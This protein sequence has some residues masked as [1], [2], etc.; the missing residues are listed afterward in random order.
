[1][2]SRDEFFAFAADV[3]GVAP[4]SLSFETTLGTIPEWDSMAQLRL[5]VEMESRWGAS[6]PFAD[7]PK[8][9]SLWE[10][11]RRLNSLSPKKAVAVDLDGTL[12]NGVVGEDGAAAL[13]PNAALLAELKALKERGVLLTILS[14]NNLGDV[15]PAFE[16]GL[17][18]PLSADDFLFPQID[19]EPKA[20]NLARLAK[21]L[22]LGTDAFVFV[23]DSPV[24][25]LEMASRL[26]D[27]AVASFPPVLSAYFPEVEVTDED[28]RKTEEYREEAERRKFLSEA[29]PADVWDALGCWLDVHRMRPDEA[30]RVAQLSQRANQ[31]STCTNRYAADD[32]VALAADAATRVYVVRAGDDFGEM[33]LVAFV[34][35]RGGEVADFTMSCRAAGRGLEE[36]TWAEVVR[37]LRA[38][39]VRELRAT[40]RDSGRNAPVRDLFERLGF[41]LAAE[42]PGK[43]SSREYRRSL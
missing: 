27:V 1:M 38:G 35:V 21:R 14:K 18:A 28:R 17:L 5:V 24:E 29:R 10:L 2:V 31:F 26:P 33:G 23:D 16:A 36:R 22:N 20:E 7:V 32:V 30:A 11:F 12:W 3:L 43:R 15:R 42:T 13:V 4:A 37:D 34:V 9:T 25:R 41:S 6:V 19:W 8:A 40:W 39:G